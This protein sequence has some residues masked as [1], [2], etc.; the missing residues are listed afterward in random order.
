MPTYFDKLPEELNIMIW[1]KVHQMRMMNIKTDLKI[2]HM[3]RSSLFGGLM[4]MATQLCNKG[5]YNADLR[6]D[7]NSDMIWDTEW[8][9]KM[10]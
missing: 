10:W 8:K 5:R 3:Y 6:G 9:I 4:I 7:S 2:H 1:K